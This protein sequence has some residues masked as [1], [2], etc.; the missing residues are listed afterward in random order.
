MVSTIG[1]IG[2]NGFIGNNLVK[3]F[4]GV[5]ITKDSPPSRHTILINANGNSR[6]GLPE[7]DPLADFD[8]SV[9]SV[10]QSVTQ[11]EYDTYV[12]L[13]SCEVYGDLTQNTKED[14]VLDVTKMSRYGLSKYL[15][16]SIVR[17]YCKKWLII[18]LNGPIGPGMKK[19]PVYDIL[20]G[21]K[22]WLSGKSQFQ[23]IHTKY[24]SQFI[25]LLLDSGVTNEVYNFT[26]HGTIALNDVMSILNR[27]I[28]C[29]DEP[30]VNHNI[31]TIK[32]GRLMGGLPSSINSVFEVRKDYET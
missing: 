13:S 2:G 21:D 17:K 28:S 19:G 16:E 8:L 11:M 24:L 20:K 12:Y 18:R 22:L 26:G 30:V 25:R 31:S 14:T 15:A 27:R 1:V 7:V 29:P 4:Q 9:R 6:K 10:L 3:D 32:A 23:I 5:S